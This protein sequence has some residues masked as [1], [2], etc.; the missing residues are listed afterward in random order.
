[1][2]ATPR[3]DL[4]FIE[5]QLPIARLSVESYT[6]RKAN[7]GQTLVGLGKWWGRK[8]LVLCRATILGLL[9]PAT[10]DP[11]KDRQV[12]LSL[13]L[14]DDDGTLRRRSGT[15]PVK[16]LFVRLPPSDRAH[17]FAEESSVNRVRWRPGTTDDQKAEL[18]RRT[19]LSMSYDERLAY[20]VRSEQVDGPSEASWAFINTHLGTQASTLQELV[21]ELGRRRFGHVPRVGD[22]FC[23][24]GSV[25]FEAARLGCDAYGADLNPAA[26]LL[27]WAALNL[28][29]G[30]LPAAK[31]GYAIQKKVFDQTDARICE[32][33]IEHSAPDPS[34]GRKWRADAFLYCVEAKCPECGW[35]NPLL[36]SL[37]IGKGTL[38][39][40]TL[41]CDA[42]R[43][44]VQIELQEGASEAAMARAAS[45]GTIRKS[46]LH[47]ANTAC[48]KTTPIT[49]VRGDG[50]GNTGTARSQLR[51]WAKDDIAP[52]SADIFRERLFGIRWVDTWLDVDANECSKRRY[53]TPTPADLQRESEVA[54][55]VERN[56]QRWAASG[57]V[58]T[59]RI[60]PG[61][62]TERLIRERGWTHWHHLFN[63]RQLLLLGL[64]AENSTSLAV[65]EIESAACLL[66]L[67]KCA[68]H[69]SRLSPWSPTAGK[70]LVDHVFSDQALNTVYN[71]GVRSMTALR[72]AWFL[73]VKDAPV[74]G[75]SRVESIDVRGAKVQRDVWITDPP[76]ADAVSYDEVSEFFL[77]WG[78]GLMG[79]INRA[80]GTDSKR[81][82]AVR[83]SGSEFNVE[84]AAAYRSLQEAMPDNGLQ[85]VMFTHQDVS[86]WAD[87]ALVLWAAG[88]R[89]TAAWCIATETG[90]AGG[91]GNYVQGTVLLVL[92]K[93]TSTEEVFLDEIHADIE[94]EVARQLDTMRA[95]D[96][97]HEPNFSETDYQ[98]AAYAA[99]LRVITAKPIAEIDPLRELRKVR[100]RGERSALAEVIESA[101][102]LANDHLVPRGIERDDWKRL[103]STERF[104]LKGV[105]LEAHGEKRVG[106]YQE[107]ARGFGAVGY[108]D[109][110][111]S[112]RANSARLKTPSE[113]AARNLRT[114]QG[115][116]SAPLRDLL[117][118]VYIVTRG[119]SP[120][121]ALQWLKTELTADGYRE[122]RRRFV[123]FADYLAALQH[124]SS[125][126][127]WQADAK[128]AELLAGALRNDHV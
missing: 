1:M 68:D 61:K 116:G 11:A 10:D 12:F 101:K 27:T 35:L 20:C 25:P 97:V 123:Q 65:D 60:E 50:L 82:L 67:W 33:G 85:V 26:T 105:E 120:R 89:V 96:D 71:F 86:V 98:L 92:R 55:F 125:L 78:A 128:A 90:P 126:A 113:M 107:L 43:R 14:M 29:G 58:P 28:V 51:A 110:M 100:A 47:C 15:F 38:T 108:D 45:L 13:M 115:F 7:M 112:V 121:D 56:W 81:P 2:P 114:A 6:E 32:L 73:R 119:D 46:Q 88:L 122:H 19:F 31:R 49:A 83:G 39:V 66:G 69:D 44:S 70:E 64:L 21:R 75:D 23:G 8:P 93:R 30:G 37:V 48:G 59:R 104:Y 40:A 9:L 5:T 79:R 76:Y 34:T 109:M 18:Q 22:A 4:T 124:N 62:E 87:L 72:S 117:F 36:P 53:A 16:E 102:R 91:E 54:A 127:H 103:E 77:G 57:L 52:Q 17:Y 111:E 24:G 106:S 63:P 99:A 95:M 41:R 84:M 74:H 94:A 118:A 42:D 3:G 80:W